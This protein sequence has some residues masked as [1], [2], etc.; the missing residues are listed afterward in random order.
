MISEISR[1]YELNG[2]RGGSP[3]L[4]AFST[5]L[6]FSLQF[7]KSLNWNPFNFL[8]NFLLKTPPGIATPRW[9]VDWGMAVRQILLLLSHSVC[10]LRAFLTHLLLDYETIYQ[11]YSTIRISPNTHCFHK[12]K[13]MQFGRKGAHGENCYLCPCL[14]VKY[15]KRTRN[16]VTKKKKHV[17]SKK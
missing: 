17:R 6:T 14:K 1:G 12:S 16:N 15:L 13:I 2:T 5:S 11:I 3:R 9:M 4:K 10:H 8:F 7:S